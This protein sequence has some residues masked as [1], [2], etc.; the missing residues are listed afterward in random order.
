MKA[1]D[2]M[3][4]DVVTIGK[5]ASVPE[6][7]QLMLDHHISGLPVV[8]RQNRL[9]G[10]VTE[11][12]FLRRAELDTER[13]RPRWLEYVLSDAAL[14]GDYVKSHARVVEAVM[15]EDVVTVAE[16]ASLAEV[17]NLMERLRVKRLPVIRA[18]KLAGIV[19]RVDVM[20]ALSA[21]IRRPDE[22]PHPD[23]AE[24]KR[25]VLAELERHHWFQSLHTGIEV[26]GGVVTL[27]GF[28]TSDV[29]R[30]YLHVLTESVPGVVGVKD[31]LTW[32]ETASGFVMP[33]PADEEE[34]GDD[35]QG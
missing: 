24:L 23:D 30:K 4:T 14:V 9:I 6:A 20:R 16:N 34:S 13:Q 19:S 1:A 27:R 35:R 32:L 2:I 7:I 28:I 26:Q 11:G 5:E 3:T 17:V 33:I 31:A 18:G 29:Q 10:I 12:D 8:D 25:R 22:E 15:T 21:I